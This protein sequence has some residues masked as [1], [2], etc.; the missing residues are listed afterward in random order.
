MGNERRVRRGRKDKGKR[1]TIESGKEI[2][3]DREKES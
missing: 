1:Q 3:R 2:M